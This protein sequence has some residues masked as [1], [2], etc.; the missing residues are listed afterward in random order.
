MIQKLTVLLPTRDRADTLRYSLKTVMAQDIPNIEILISD[1]FSGADVKTVADEAMV[2]DS[3]VRYIR[4]SSR[5]GMS[6]HWEFALEHVTGDWVT[7]LGDDDG[8]L[9]GSIGKLFEISKKHPDIKAITAANCA[10]LW[11]SEG[12][13]NGK[14]SLVSGNGYEV[15]NSADVMKKTMY[16]EIIAM[17]TIYTGGF[18]SMDVI[19]DVKSKNPNGKFFQSLNP[20]IYS[21]FAI[22]SVTNN[23]IYS[24]KAFSISGT[25]KH[26]ISNLCKNKSN[27][28]IKNID[29]FHENNIPVHSTLGNTAVGSMQVI[30]YEAFMQSENLRS[31]NFGVTTQQQLE[32]A[33]ASSSKNV[34]MQV[35]DYVKLVAERNNLDYAKILKGARIKLYISK[36]KKLGRK[37]SRKFLV[38]SKLPKKTIND[39]NVRTIYDA[40]K[41]CGELIA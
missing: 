20:D 12:Q 22:S 9:P 16:G 10:F 24:Y 27:E 31:N 40:A 11:P 19:R 7:V 37:V 6:E 5:M 18:V 26:S 34:R 32:L 36:L 2:S 17:P 1:N 30:M 35:I 23:F 4:T 13:N 14:L 8:L 15:R 28:E 39:N 25:S 41:K 3:R 21:G 38:S 29:F 33:I